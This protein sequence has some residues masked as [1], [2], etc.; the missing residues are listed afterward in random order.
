MDFRTADRCGLYGW[1]SAA[2]SRSLAPSAPPKGGSLD[3]RLGTQRAQWCCSADWPPCS[4]APLHPS[5]LRRS[6]E[7]GSSGGGGMS[8]KGVKRRGGGGSS[9]GSE[10]GAATPHLPR[11]GSQQQ[12]SPSLP[13]APS[14]ALASSTASNHGSQEEGMGLSGPEEDV[15]NL[16]TRILSEHITTPTCLGWFLTPDGSVVTIDP[17]WIDIKNHPLNPQTHPKYPTWP[18][19]CALHRS[20]CRGGGLPSKAHDVYLPSVSYVT[21]APPNGSG[22]GSTVEATWP[23]ATPPPASSVDDVDYVGSIAAGSL[24]SAAET[25]DAA[26]TRAAI[27]HMQSKIRR[28]KELIRGE[29]TTS[30]DNVNEYLKLAANA[31]RQQLPRIKAVFEKKNQKSAHA[32]SQLQ[33]KLEAYTRRVRDI[34]MHGLPPAHHRQPREVLRDMGQGLKHVGGNIRDGI[35]GFSGTV[36]SKPREFAHLIKNKFGSAD[37][38]NTLA[39]NGADMGGASE[40]DGSRG[41]GRTHHG[42]ATLPAQGSGPLGVAKFPSEEEEGG[43]ASGVVSG[44]GDGSGGGPLGGS[45]CSSVTSESLPPP[46]HHAHPCSPRHQPTSYQLDLIFTELQ[47]RREECERL[48]EE[49]E[50]IK[51]LQGEVAFLGQSLQEERFRSERLE[52]QV[53][54]LTE[55]H[56]VEVENLKQ[57]I[58]DV[59]EKVQYQSE[60]RLRD[61]HEMLES[62]HTKIFKL[63]HQQQ[64]QQQYVTLEGIE[65]G[66]ARALVVKLINVVLTVLQVVLL[67]VATAAGIMTPFLKTRLRILTTILF[68]ASIVFVLKQWPEMSEVGGHLVRRV[69]DALA[70]K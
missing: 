47:E 16:A 46:A 63:E 7:G 1:S 33:K 28:T 41:S 8:S 13:V 53:N 32:I 68:I 38:I 36:M 65:N 11:V 27:E 3:R 56:Q 12:A 61:I 35:T 22:P 40:E 69:R 44:V 60:E 59:E 5:P 43:G 39:R 49:V 58:S 42:S 50:T 23:S 48:R 52:E 25:P 21:P 29:Q 70:V 57:A 17:S 37:N 24:C 34:E 62:C 15:I 19:K 67:V 55:L 45:E 66:N 31:D 26:R 54:D 18:P 14:P 6:G 10:G 51:R 9:G 20:A 4:T 30:D 64:Q 2:E